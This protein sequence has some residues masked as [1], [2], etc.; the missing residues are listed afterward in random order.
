[1]HTIIVLSTTLLFYPLNI[2]E[3]NDAIY[4]RKLYKN[5]PLNLLT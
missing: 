4:P 3:S 2:T 1:M 5:S